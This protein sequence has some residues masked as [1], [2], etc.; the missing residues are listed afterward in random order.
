MID[1]GHGGSD[2]GTVGCNA[3]T[4]KEITLAVGRE[5][6]QL[7]EKNDIR[8]VL[9]RSDDSTVALDDRTSYAN[10]INADLFVSLHANNAASN[11]VQGVETYY[12]DNALLTQ[13]FSSSDHCLCDVMSSCCSKSKNLARTIHTHLV[14]QAK[15]H[16]AQ[17]CDRQIKKSV[18]QVLLG[19]DMP[20]VLVELGF[21]SCEREAQLLSSHEYQRV[22]ARGL[23]EGIR[24]YCATA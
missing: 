16:N 1:C 12:F 15:T 3:V 10:R 23:Y 19:T 22:L 18:S 8:V 7:L 11:R 9:T 21:L 6:A 24:S 2:A 4:E 13:C 20:S 17:V 14:A 5:L